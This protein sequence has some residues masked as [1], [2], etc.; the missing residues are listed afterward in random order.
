MRL[1][2]RRWRV[3]IF[4]CVDDGSDG[5]D[6]GCVIVV[7]DDGNKITSSCVASFEAVTVVAVAVLTMVAVVKMAVVARAGG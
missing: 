6:V 3:S 5:S 1:Q 4:F 7:D 2:W